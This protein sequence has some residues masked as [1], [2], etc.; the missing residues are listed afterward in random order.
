MNHS[1]VM[2]FRMLDVEELQELYDAM[3]T[4]SENE[5]CTDFGST[6]RHQPAAEAGKLV[7]LKEVATDIDF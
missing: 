3:Q 4:N 2:D 1:D 6:C 7:F 5:I